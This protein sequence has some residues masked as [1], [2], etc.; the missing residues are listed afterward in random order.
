MALAEVEGCVFDEQQLRVSHGYESL[1]PVARE[2]F[3]NHRHLAGAGRAGDAQAVIESWA[4]EMRS[5]WPN[6]TF[7]IYREAE[8]DEVTIR[9]HLVRPGM[10]NWCEQG[11]EVITVGDA[12]SR[13]GP[14]AAADRPRD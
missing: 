4:A 3:V 5:R 6:R 1:D 12:E 7:R 9:F 8:A 2:A 13:A 10:P 14:A 11:V